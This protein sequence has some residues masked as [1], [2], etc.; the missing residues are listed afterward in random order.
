MG[1][2]LQQNYQNCTNTFLVQTR[3]QSKAKN[4]KVPNTHSG[5]TPTPIGKPGKEMKPIII[6]DDEPTIDDLDT[7]TRIDKYVQ[8]TTVTQTSD[9]PIRQGNRGILYPEPITRPLPKPPELIDTSVEPKQS[10]DSTPSVDFE[11]NYPIKKAFAPYHQGNSRRL[12]NQS[13]FQGHIQIFSSKCLAKEKVCKT[14]GGRLV[15]EIDPIGFFA[16]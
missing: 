6:I 7:K 5:M 10:V 1:K 15:R 3:S 9:K 8:D 4:A 13:L 14:K 12:F 11:E 2:I 16:I